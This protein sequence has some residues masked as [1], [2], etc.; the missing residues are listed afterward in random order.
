MKNDYTIEQRALLVEGSDVWHTQKDLAGRQLLL[1]DGPHGLRKQISFTDNLG[2][3]GSE[4]A[5]CYPP[6]SLLA[7][8]FD[9]KLTYR[10]GTLL[11]KEAKKAGVNIVLGPGINIK[12]TPLCGRNFEYFSEDPLLTGKMG[13]AYVKGIE[14]EKIG[15]SVKHFCCNNQE[16]LRY[17]MDAIVDQRTLHEIYLKAFKATLAEEPASLMASYNKVNGFYATENPYLHQVLRNDWQY[18]GLLISDWGAVSNRIKALQYGCDL[19]MPS[20]KAYNVNKIISE[21]KVSEE[22]RQA[23]ND[24]SKRIIAAINKYQITSSEE[25]DFEAHHHEAYN[26]AAE[27]IVLLKNE[28]ILPLKIE[29][30]VLFIG[31]L[32]QEFRYQGGGSSY[33]NSYR[34]EKIPDLLAD[35]NADFCLGYTLDVDGYD[36]DLSREALNKA[37]Q[38][39]KIV[40]FVGLPENYETE[41]VDR[42]DLNIP[43][44]QEQLFNELIKINPNI[45]CVILA[46]SVVNLVPLQQ[47]RALMM[48]YLSGEA[49]ALAIID[50]LYGVKNPSGRLAETFISDIK[51]ANVKLNH[52]AR[53]YYDETIFVGYRYY[54]TFAKNVVYP[55]G[56]GLSYTTFSYRNF[57]VSS[58]ILSD[59]LTVKC[60]LKNTGAYAGAEVIQLYI[61]NNESSVYKA[62]RELRAFQKVY[63]NV[64]EE[65]EV[66]F[67]LTKQ[68]FSYYD[69]NAKDFIANTG[70]Y[71]I[72]LA[73]NVNDI[74]CEEFVVIVAEDPRFVA[75][76][77]TSYHKKQ[78]DVS[79]FAKVYQKP[80]PAKRA[81]IRP[82]S[83]DATLRML[84]W[85][86]LGFIVGRIIVRIA[87]K[88]YVNAQMRQILQATIL[89]TPLRT[90]ALNSEGALPLGVAEGIIDLCNYHLIRGTKKIIKG[91]KKDGNKVV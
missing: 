85:S 36:E 33:V 44:G 61:E 80:L 15:C 69:I 48:A 11:G 58:R 54:N 31:A 35:K 3:Q 30:K 13:A 14:G 27:S 67:K 73:H 18:K 12:R 37:A 16:Y 88:R 9:P 6:A 2:L 49:G 5:I 79:D 60:K 81:R 72:Q 52:D 51:E 55:F 21:A 1:A 20:T 42:Q 90:L 50:L 40:M 84:R 19:E 56:H 34:V 23:V 76:P 32:G 86:L 45:T 83:L 63:L 62:K 64:D 89:N 39:E 91:I 24:S 4:V 59:E 68:D 8:S 77:K 38:Y 82:F 7:C 17:N 78:Y 53:V 41:G 46:G 22:I 28:Q 47:A 25:I 70:E 43:K 74:I 66:I 75:H 29:E 87:N 65:V 10:L 71:K 57:K 26:M